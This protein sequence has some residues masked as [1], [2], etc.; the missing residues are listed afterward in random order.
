MVYV[1]LTG[2]GIIF[3]KPRFL[4]LNFHTYRYLCIEIDLRLNGFGQESPSLAICREKSQVRT[5]SQFAATREYTKYHARINV[6][7][8]RRTTRECDMSV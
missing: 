3:S 1:K 5:G 8:L 7:R 4:L 6:L 2:C